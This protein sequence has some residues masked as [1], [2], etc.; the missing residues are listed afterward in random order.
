MIT[1]FK[2]CARAIFSLL[3]K[4]PPWFTKFEFE[5]FFSLFY[6]ISTQISYIYK[7]PFKSV[8]FF[9]IHPVYNTIL[10]YRRLLGL[11]K[12]K[13]DYTTFNIQDYTTLYTTLYVISTFSFVVELIVIYPVPVS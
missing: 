13:Q 10:H 7:K 2:F 11:Y 6:I 9:F 12:A 3:E 1:T 4:T 5:N 8:Q